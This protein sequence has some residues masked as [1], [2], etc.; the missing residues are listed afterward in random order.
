[1]TASRTVSTHVK[2][3][4]RCA[5]G[6]DVSLVQA[7]VLVSCTIMITTTILSLL[8]LSVAPSAASSPTLNSRSDP[9]HVPI[10]RRSTKSR[11]SHDWAK[12]ADNLRA[13]YNY[14]TVRSKQKRTG[15]TVGVSITNLVRVNICMEPRL[16]NHSLC[17]RME[18]PVILE[19]STWAHRMLLSYLIVHSWTL[20]T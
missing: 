16:L 20:T 10:T 17:T 9:I 5:A 2:R 11:V 19:L 15:N 7:R 8:V 13:K 18:T 12:T 1:M 14:K 6:S 4:L 3:F